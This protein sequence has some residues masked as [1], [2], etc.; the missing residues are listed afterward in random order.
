MALIL[1]DIYFAFRV[2]ELFS[3]RY[4]VNEKNQ[5]LDPDVVI[6]GKGL[7]GGLPLS[8]ICGKKQFS[9]NYDPDYLL[10]VN[11]VS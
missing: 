4:F 11:K 10:K 7:A 6:L 3:F 5:P 9:M 2:P 8:V 1:D